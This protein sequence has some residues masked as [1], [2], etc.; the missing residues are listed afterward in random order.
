MAGASSVHSG[1]N[2]GLRGP[3]SYVEI[4]N[5]KHARSGI[6][7]QNMGDQELQNLRMSTKT[8]EFGGTSNSISHIRDL[9]RKK[10]QASIEASHMQQM[11]ERQGAVSQ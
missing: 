4:N 10:L 8:I 3:G 6:G 1:A 7:F 2:I 11:S 9:D 5:N